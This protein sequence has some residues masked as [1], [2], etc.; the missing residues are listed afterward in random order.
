MELETKLIILVGGIVSL[1]ISVI[2]WRSVNKKDLSN[3]EKIKKDL[4]KKYGAK[5]GKKSLWK[6]KITFGGGSGKG[7]GGKRGQ[8]QHMSDGR[9]R[10]QEK[11]YDAKKEWESKHWD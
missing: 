11:R 5:V 4:K 2:L 8:P 1:V 3:N 7:G 6:I 9:D 10:E